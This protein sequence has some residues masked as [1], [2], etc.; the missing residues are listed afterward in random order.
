MQVK[1]IGI[2]SI[3]NAI[4]CNLKHTPSAVECVP[5]Q[6]CISAIVKVASYPIQML[7]ILAKSVLSLLSRHLSD[8]HKETLVLDA[9]EIQTFLNCLQGKPSL[10]KAMVLPISRYM[11]DVIMAS[12]ENRI[13]FMQWNAPMLLTM[14]KKKQE[15]SVVLGMF[16]KLISLLTKV[17]EPPSIKVLENIVHSTT[18]VVAV[19]SDSDTENVDQEPTKA[20]EYLTEDNFK[21]FD[22]FHCIMK[23]FLVYA[24]D[25]LASST[26]LT[27]FT[28]NSITTFMGFM[29]HMIT[30]GEEIHTK[31]VASFAENHQFLSLIYQLLQKWPGKKCMV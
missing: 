29:R 3:L 17:E 6:D 28:V 25:I 10:N 13:A 18:T 26:D 31:I 22:L 15:D 8:K 21:Y 20:F 24:E 5:S 9:I 27:P 11:E 2:Q 16:D 7:K 4:Y 30:Q 23:H 1:L 19:D 14:F 12:D